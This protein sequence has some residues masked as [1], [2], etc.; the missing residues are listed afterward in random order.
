VLLA[1][2]GFWGWFFVLMIMIPLMCIWVF[3]LADIFARMDLPGW[4]KALWVIVVIILPLLGMLVYFIV[5]PQTARELAVDQAYHRGGPRAALAADSTKKLQKLS[6]LKDKGD[7]TQ[8]EFEKQKA[9][10]L[11]I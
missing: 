3:S 9:G 5:R 1:E 8:E 10:L 7:I 6:E 4:A 11:G 2:I